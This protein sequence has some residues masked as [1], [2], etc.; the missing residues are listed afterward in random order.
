M[1]TLLTLQ[2]LPDTGWVQPPSSPWTITDGVEP[3]SIGSGMSDIPTYAIIPT[4]GRP[5]F[6][7][8]LEAVLYQV[9]RVIVVEG[10]PN[11]A[12]VD[13]T[14]DDHDLSVIREPDLNISK[15]W[16]LGLSLIADRVQEYHG[17]IKWNVV[18]LNDDA[19]IPRGWVAA[20]SSTMRLM[21][22][23]AASTG[24]PN[25]WPILHQNPGPVDLSTRLQGYAFM[26]AG[27]KGVRA[28]EQLHWYFSDDHV[29]WMSRQHGGTLSIPGHHVRHLYPNGQMTAELQVQIAEDA[30][31]FTAYWAGMRPW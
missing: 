31:A 15:W 14:T 11:A 8:C 28:N 16:N 3:R 25:P 10:G 13:S 5:C 9:D 26:L 30:K 21:G 17:K 4:N 22:A 18:I 19:I 7:E 29:D 20:V 1:G 24:N 6:K 23:A 27:E 2:G 12:Y